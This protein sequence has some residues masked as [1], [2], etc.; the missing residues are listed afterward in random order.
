MTKSYVETSPNIEDHHEKFSEALLNKEPKGLEITLCYEQ[1]SLCVGV[2]RHSFEVEYT[3]THTHTHTLSTLFLLL[4]CNMS[5]MYLNGSYPML[6]SS[7]IST[8]LCKWYVFFLSD[9]T[10]KSCL[11]TA[12]W[13]L[14]FRAT[15]GICVLASLCILIYLQRRSCERHLR[16]NVPSSASPAWTCLVQAVNVFWSV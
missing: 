14:W 11:R 15:R 2:K 4:L 13:R 5:R 1:T 8:C 6:V 3:H 9:R 16:H 12:T 7:V 10:P